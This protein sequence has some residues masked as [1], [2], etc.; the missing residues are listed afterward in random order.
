[1]TTQKL[2]FNLLK[3]VAIV[4]VVAAAMLFFSYL[5]AQATSGP[6]SEF[7]PERAAAITQDPSFSSNEK[8]DAPPSNWSASVQVNAAPPT[9]L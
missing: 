4:L 1:M 6:S 2:C 3:S 7:G 8:G 5:P 9:K